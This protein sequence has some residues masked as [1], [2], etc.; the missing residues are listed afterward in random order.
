MYKDQDAI[1]RTLAHAGKLGT[2]LEGFQTPDVAAVL[3]DFSSPPNRDSEQ[4]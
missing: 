3:F 1:K 2:R 4:R